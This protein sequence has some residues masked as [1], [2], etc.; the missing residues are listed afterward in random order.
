MDHYV[1]RLNFVINYFANKKLEQNHAYKSFLLE[2]LSFPLPPVIVWVD[3][4][5]SFLSYQARPSFNLKVPM[6]NRLNSLISLDFVRILQSMAKV[7]ENPDYRQKKYVIVE[8]EDQAVESGSVPVVLKHP[9]TVVVVASPTGKAPPPAVGEIRL[10]KLSDAL[11]V[12]GN[13]KLPTYVTFSN[14]LSHFP[15]SRHP[16]HSEFLSARLFP[17]FYR[18]VTASLTRLRSCLGQ[19]R[20]SPIPMLKMLLKIQLLI[21]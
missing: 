19:Q 10:E 3:L 20:R 7:E 2:L 15:S 18:P 4:L 5:Y 1:L 12:R 14:D 17:Y 6:M 13:K 11:K 8:K 9:D 21:L 16:F